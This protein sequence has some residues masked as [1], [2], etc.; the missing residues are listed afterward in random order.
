M[1]AIRGLMGISWFRKTS[2]FAFGSS[3]APSERLLLESCAKTS[4]YLASTM[5]SLPSGSL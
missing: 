1:S 4:L 3:S 5:M 2:N